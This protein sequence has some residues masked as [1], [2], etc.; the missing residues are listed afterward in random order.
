MFEES[1]WLTTVVKLEPNVSVHDTL[2]PFV[3]SQVIVAIIR[4]PDV[5]GDTNDSAIEVSLAPGVL[6][7]PCTYSMLDVPPAADDELML[8][9]PELLVSCPR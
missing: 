1:F 6:P 2:V 5:T 9:A 4:L 7:V 8:K 3:L